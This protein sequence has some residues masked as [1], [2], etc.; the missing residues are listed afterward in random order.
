MTPLHEKWQLRGPASL[1]D[2]E[3]L[4]LLLYDGAEGSAGQAEALLQGCGGTLAAVA[5]TDVARLRM[6]AGTGLKRALRLAAAAELGRRMAAAE[7]SLTVQSI[8]SSEEVVRIFR[9][10]LGE[11]RH[12]ECWALYLSSSNRIVEEARISQGGVEGT[13]VDHR[14]VV[15]RALELLSTQL[16]LVHNHPSGLAEPSEADRKLTQRIAAAAQLFD[17]RLLDHLIL[18]RDGSFSFRAQGLL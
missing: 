18:S 17:I 3:L 14:L 13:V 10:R 16:I 11:L 15:K 2:A 7:A 8:T 4:A 6:T 1:S 5:R 12:E 9:P